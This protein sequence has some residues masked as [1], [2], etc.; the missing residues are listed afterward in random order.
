MNKYNNFS[1]IIQTDIDNEAVIQSYKLCKEDFNK[2]SIMDILTKD[3]DDIKPIAIINLNSIDNKKEADFFLSYLTG[4]DGRIREAISHILCELKP[5]NYYTDDLSIKTLIN[6]LLDINPNV[7]RN[8]IYFIEQSE[9]LKENLKGPIIQ[10]TNEVLEELSKYIKESSPFIENQSKSTK[11]HAKNKLT[12][13]LYWL[14]ET[15]SVLDVNNIKNLNE[16]LT[17]TS[18]FLDY[19]IREKTALIL[20]KMENPPI[21]LLQKLKEDEN[22]YVKNKFLC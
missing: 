3:N 6:G 17:K 13:N 19:T 7:V 18:N 20:S 16:I 22:I 10:K 8:L 12:F 21:E 1:N 14:L 5:D 9:I 4:Q 2:A 11:N 15:I